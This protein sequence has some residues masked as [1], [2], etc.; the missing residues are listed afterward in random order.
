MRG[1]TNTV[2]LTGKVWRKYERDPGREGLGGQGSQT[3]EEGL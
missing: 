3:L 2:W 1:L